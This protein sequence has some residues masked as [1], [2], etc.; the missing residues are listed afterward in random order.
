[1]NAS[2]YVPLGA[3]TPSPVQWSRSID[4][5]LHKSITELERLS[6]LGELSDDELFELTLLTL[7]GEDGLEGVLIELD[8]SLTE[9]ELAKRST[10]TGFPVPLMGVYPPNGLAF[11]LLNHQ[12]PRAGS[13][14]ELETI[15]SLPVTSHQIE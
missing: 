4:E 9:L 3:G 12:T 14:G 11:D 13:G 7:L 8:G 15:H 10:R 5:L 1:M 6:E 2:L